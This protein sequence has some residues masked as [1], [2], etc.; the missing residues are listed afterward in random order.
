MTKRSELL[1]ERKIQ[2]T[3]G[4]SRFTIAKLVHK[5]NHASLVGEMCSEASTRH[6]MLGS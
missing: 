3:G 1:K 4:L 5:S 6:E 2:L